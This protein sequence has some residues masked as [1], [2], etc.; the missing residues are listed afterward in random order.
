MQKNKIYYKY[1]R[2]H[3]VFI[4]TDIFVLVEKKR[5][6]L[7]HIQNEIPKLVRGFETD[8][9]IILVMPTSSRNRFAIPGRNRK[10]DLL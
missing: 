9:T 8:A 4:A 10:V 5:A 2:Y 3:L 1:M 6:V 7:F